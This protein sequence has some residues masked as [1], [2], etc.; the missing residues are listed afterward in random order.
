METDSGTETEGEV[1]REESQNPFFT[2]Q[3]QA[4][5]PDAQEIQKRH[6]NKRRRRL[7]TSVE[8]EEEKEFDSEKG[9]NGK[10]EEDVEH[11]AMVILDQE[12]CCKSRK[13]NRRAGLSELTWFRRCWLSL[14]RDARQ[15]HTLSMIQAG[16]VPGARA[17]KERVKYAV[18]PFGRV[19]RIMFRWLFCVGHNKLL[20]LVAHVVEN[21]AVPRVHGH[22]GKRPNNALTPCQVDSITSWILE[23]ADTYGEAAPGRVRGRSAEDGVRDVELIYLPACYTI[24][25]LHRLFLS[26]K[27]GGVPDI[28]GQTFTRIMASD[29]C[30]HIRIRSPR[31]DMCDTC[32]VLR[33]ELAGCDGLDEMEELGQ[34]LADH[35]RLA[36]M[37]REEYKRDTERSVQSRQSGSDGNGNEATHISFDYA[38]NLWLPHFVDQPAELYFLS[39]LSV[40]MFGVLNETTR[41]QTNYIYLESDGGKGS[42]AVASMLI[43]YFYRLP[44]A[45]RRRLVFHCDNC[46]GQ[47]KNNAIVKLLAWLCLTERAEVI[48]LKFMLR[49]HTKFGPDGFFGLIKSAFARQDAFTLQH[50]RDAIESSS[51]QGYNVAKAFP[52]PHFKDFRAGLDELFQNLPRISKYHTFRF[53]RSKP[54][55]V[56]ARALGEEEWTTCNMLR[57]ALKTN[58]RTGYEFTPATLEA[59]G[60][61]PKKREDYC[62]KIK[63]FIPAE[64]R[65]SVV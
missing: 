20:T 44:A 2:Q 57:G 56:E 26:D 41:R 23:F 37:A 40:P 10:E 9:D 25:L 29:T 60:L 4:S 62:K 53:D 3:S 31:S 27:P 5:Q 1:E 47:N 43:D 12:L 21:G 14:D 48:E 28:C 49:G 38:Q 35:L 45:E 46:P 22:T 54:G 61:K 18:W 59:P 63:K 19:C 34:E 13:C 30:A 50:I 64:Y 7:L 15:V 65:D 55:V 16:L 58:R 39:P 52:A 33:S 24:A 8:S 6:S 32:C 42:N 17:Q 36:R 51:T 11:W